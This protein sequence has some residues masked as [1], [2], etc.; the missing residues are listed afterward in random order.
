MSKLVKLLPILAYG[1]IPDG[2]SSALGKMVSKSLLGIIQSETDYSLASVNSLHLGG[3]LD[4]MIIRHHSS[5]L[6][7]PAEL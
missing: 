3:R 6:V 5:S 2:T 1:L 4:A 7:Y